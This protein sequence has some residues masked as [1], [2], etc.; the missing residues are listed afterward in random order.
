MELST[1]NLVSDA[2]WYP[3]AIKYASGKLNVLTS[4]TRKGGPAQKSFILSAVETKEPRM[5]TIDFGGYTTLRW[6]M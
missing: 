3:P 6:S 5:H 2:V 4:D 1:I